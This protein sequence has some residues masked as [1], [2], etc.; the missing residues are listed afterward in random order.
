[1]RMKYHALQEWVSLCG[2]NPLMVPTLFICSC[3]MQTAMVTKDVSKEGSTEDGLG[4]LE[5]R[6]FL[7]HSFWCP[8]VLLTYNLL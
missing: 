1:M 6:K 5:V 2:V 8:S 3:H 7:T 4:T